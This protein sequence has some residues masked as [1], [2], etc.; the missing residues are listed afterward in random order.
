M[1]SLLEAFERVV[2][3]RDPRGVRFPLASVLALVT[4]AFMCGRQNLSQAMRFGREHRGILR[5]LGLGE[6]GA[7][8]VPTLSRVLG[9]V[10][11]EDLQ[12]AVGLWLSGLV[13]RARR[14]RSVA[15]AV[16]GKTS[17][18]AGVHV[19][20]VFLHDLEVAVWQERVGKKHNEISALRRVLP[21]LFETYPFLRIL[22]GDAMFA[23]NPLCSELIANGRHYLFQIKA[24]Q[25]DLRER[26]EIVFS[27]HLSRPPRESRLTGEKKRLR[28][29]P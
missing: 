27:R 28:R 6:R 10:R 19:L 14:G 29:G 1:A 3:E 16:D 22:T 11:V 9:Q 21:K 12:A 7:P 17:R 2:D 4:V 20:N 24:D 23:G 26:L 18:A 8:S 25:R 13:E 15:A 5:A